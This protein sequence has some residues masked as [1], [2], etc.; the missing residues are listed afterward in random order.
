MSKEQKTYLIQYVEEHRELQS[1]KLS[2][3]F[4]FKKAQC[5]WKELANILNSM[6]GARK[7][8]EKW[9]KGTGGGPPPKD[10]VNSDDDKILGMIS[11]VAVGGH[12][13]I[14][15]SKALFIPYH[16]I[17]IEEVANV[18]WDHNYNVDETDNNTGNV[19]IVETLSYIDINNENVDINSELIEKCKKG[20]KEKLKIPKK[21]NVIQSPVVRKYYICH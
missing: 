17:I 19:N 2:Q 4:T 7:D 6:P 10:E 5:L 13:N 16:N 21:K 20:K 9:R 15:E 8:W 12:E 11:S 3:Q 14:T 18:A 1:G